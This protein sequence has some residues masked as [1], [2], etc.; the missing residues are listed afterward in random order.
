MEV[1][2]NLNLASP[3]H[4][5]HPMLLFKEIL[6]ILG[7]IFFTICNASFIQGAFPTQ[8]KRTEVVPIIKSGVRTDIKIFKPL[9]ILNSFKKI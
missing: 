7:E 5:E 4:D 3:G 9:S 1:M 6:D 2:K 8:L